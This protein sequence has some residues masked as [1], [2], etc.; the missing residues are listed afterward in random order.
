M[1]KFR[2]L[3]SI[4][5]EQIQKFKRAI[6]R[7]NGTNAKETRNFRQRG[8]KEDICKVRNSLQRENSLIRI[9]FTFFPGVTI[10]LAPRIQTCRPFLSL[11][12]NGLLEHACTCYCFQFCGKS[13]NR[14]T[15][16]LVPL[17]RFAIL[18]NQ[19][20]NLLAEG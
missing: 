11:R 19:R 17:C 10:N 1:Y 3:P 8:K 18:A 7:S 9:S 15:A 14:L 2:S 20:E 4:K 5:H 13:R 12:G 16:N 6:R